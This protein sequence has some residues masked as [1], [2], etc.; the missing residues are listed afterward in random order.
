[1]RQPVSDIR[2]VI[3]DDQEIYRSALSG[4]LEI[5]GGYAVVGTAATGEEA[6]ELTARTAVD[7][8]FMDL[9]LP[10]INGI[11]ATT[12]I[13]AVEGAPRV[14]VISTDRDGLTS[15]AIS[16]SGAM[17]G[18]AKADLDPDWLDQ[19]RNEINGAPP[20]PAEQARSR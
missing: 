16:R 17:G 7:L 8:V 2:V 3:V 13:R 18:L 5:V 1:V 12:A 4:L 19:L 20:P 9:R 11:E 10:G 6:V 14:V 15:E